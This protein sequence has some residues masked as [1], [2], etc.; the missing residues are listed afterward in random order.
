MK[1]TLRALISV[2]LVLLAVSPIFAEDNSKEDVVYSDEDVIVRLDGDTAGGTV[3]DSSFTALET[4]D[5]N[6]YLVS[7]GVVGEKTTADLGKTVNVELTLTQT[8]PAVASGYTREWKVFVTHGD[9]SSEVL[10]PTVS[11]QTVK[12]SFTKCS[13]FTDAYKD[14]KNASG[15]TDYNVV[16]TAD[17]D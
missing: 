9:G 2:L 10:T 4:F 8:V 7:E 13:N 15:N 14:T 6:A 3:T 17:K 12:F 5:L 11:G 1:K 16:N